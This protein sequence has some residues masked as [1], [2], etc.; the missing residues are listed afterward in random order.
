M[1][2]VAGDG[3]LA[4]DAGP[5]LSFLLRAWVWPPAADWPAFLAAGLAVSI[6][7]MMVSQA[8]RLCPAALIAPFEYASIPL[9]IFWGVVIFGQWPDGAAWTG[10]A[11]ICGAG[12]YTLWRE[13]VTRTPK[14]APRSSGL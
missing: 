14:D 2:L 1:G 12:L 11:L 3:H 13:T 10:I 4:R 7:G 9:A 6:G 8:Y 5:A